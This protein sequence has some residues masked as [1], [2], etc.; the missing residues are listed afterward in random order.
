MFPAIQR[1]ARTALGN[2]ANPIFDNPRLKTF[3]RS[4]NSWRVPLPELA[5]WYKL[6]ARAMHGPKMRR[7]SGICFQFFT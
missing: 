5:L 7:S 6:V 3:Q 1:Q 2:V 4:V